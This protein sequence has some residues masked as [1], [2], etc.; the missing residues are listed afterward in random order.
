MQLDAGEPKGIYIPKGFAHGFQTLSTDV[1]LIYLHSAP[2]EPE[3]EEGIRYDDPAISIEWPLEPIN[4]SAKDSGY[5]L[6]E[7]RSI[8]SLR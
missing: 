7:A 4:V 1:E 8:K 6:L 3:L 2:Y 5:E